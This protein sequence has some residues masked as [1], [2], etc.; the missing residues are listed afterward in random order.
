MRLW[1][2]GGFSVLSADTRGHE[3]Q[4]SLLLNILQ[5]HR[6]LCSGL[7][8]HELPRNWIPPP[9]TGLQTGHQSQRAS[10]CHQ[11]APSS[12]ALCLEMQWSKKNFTEVICFCV[13]AFCSHL[14]IGG[15][16][17]VDSNVKYFAPLVRKLLL[18]SRVCGCYSNLISLVVV[19]FL[20]FDFFIRQTINQSNFATLASLHSLPSL[21]NVFSLLRCPLPTLGEISA[22]SMVTLCEYKHWG[23]ELSNRTV[24]LLFGASFTWLT[25]AF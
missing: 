13:A 24:P 6:V 16:L 25:L 10:S 20:H 4:S 1:G 3:T 19:L 9:A 15:S 22:E 12:C 18:S 23:V 14:F 21:L 11:A 2:I 5:D 8:L 17:L 7:P